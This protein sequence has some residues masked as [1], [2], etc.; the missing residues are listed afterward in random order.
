MKKMKYLIAKAL[1]LL[2]TN[3]GRYGV[4]SQKVQK[5]VKW[6]YLL[7]QREVQQT[8]RS[9]LAAH[10]CKTT[11]QTARDIERE[12]RAFIANEE[13]RPVIVIGDPHGSF[14]GLKAIFEH[15]DL[16]D[17]TGEIFVGEGKL[18]V[19]MGDYEHR[20]P[21]SREVVDYLLR[22]KAQAP[23]RRSNI[24]MVV[25][26]HE[27]EQFI[28]KWSSIASEY[29]YQ[30]GS[31]FYIPK[32]QIEHFENEDTLNRLKKNL[33][34]MVQIGKNVFT[35]SGFADD[36]LAGFIANTKLPTLSLQNLND[37]FRKEM[38]ELN[39]KK[40]DEFWELTGNQQLVGSMK[41]SDL[42]YK[43]LQTVDKGRAAQPAL[44]QML[45]WKD[46]SLMVNGRWIQHSA[47]MSKT[48]RNKQL[49]SEVSVVLQMVNQINE[50]GGVHMPAQRLFVGHYQN[51]MQVLHLKPPDLDFQAKCSNQ[52]TIEQDVVSES[53]RIELIMTDNGLNQCDIAWHEIIDEKIIQKSTTI[54]EE[55][56]PEEDPVSPEEP[57]SP[58]SGCNCIIM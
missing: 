30:R 9:L 2:L 20:G 37:Q 15:H 17:E 36:T 19:V 44:D 4:Y 32:G 10:Q 3:P 16:L 23:G 13:K 31:G 8:L 7:P 22:W 49:C 26:N 55:S 12:K 39:N 1:L 46:M 25:G 28:Y 38:N 24:F 11:I 45:I 43:T 35:H 21:D 5:K 47:D 42:L 40:L 41:R 52:G 56:T 58:E 34:F 50:L 48:E 14:L 29:G 18:V 6:R 27:M 57:V 54:V 51:Q 53:D 33:M